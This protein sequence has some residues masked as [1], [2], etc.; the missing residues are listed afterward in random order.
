MFI[1]NPKIR[2]VMNSVVDNGIYYMFIPLFGLA[3]VEGTIEGFII[4]KYKEMRKRW[5]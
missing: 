5:L 4:R 1:G 3:I 2:K